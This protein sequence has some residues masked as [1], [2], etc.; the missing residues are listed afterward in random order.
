MAEISEQTEAIIERLK[1]EG[2]LVRNTG[3]N[4]IKAV[5]M[6][7]AKFSGIFSTISANIAEQTEIMRQTLEFDQLAAKKAA[8]EA[9]KQQLDEVARQAED[10]EKSK[11]KKDEERKKTKNET[12]SSGGVITSFLSGFKNLLVKSLLGGAGAV[13]LFEV[14][15]GFFDERTQGGFSKFFEEIDWTKMTTDMKYIAT[16]IASGAK[17]FVNFVAD[18]LGTILGSISG[19]TAGAA[20][21]TAAGLG[22]LLN[23]ANGDDGDTTKRRSKL[24]N[25]VKLSALGLVLAGVGVA[26]DSAKE[27]IDKQEFSD[28]EIAGVKVGEL[29]KFGVD[30][31]DA[32]LRGASIGMM[33]GPQGAMVGAVLGA[34]VTI[35][36]KAWEFWTN[37]K[38]KNEERM[39]KDIA[40]M[41]NLMN[42]SQAK[43]RVEYIQNELSKF[44]AGSLRQ[45]ERFNELK[46]TQFYQGLTEDQQGALSRFVFSG[47]TIPGTSRN[48]EE[49]LQEQEK[50][51]TGQRRRGF[52]IDENGMIIG[53]D[54]NGPLG[55]SIGG[56]EALRL[57]E[58]GQIKY[59]EY[60]DKKIA[61]GQLP[62]GAK[63][64]LMNS[65]AQA[66][67]QALPK[68]SEGQETARIKAAINAV[69]SAAGEGSITASQMFDPNDPRNN[70]YTGYNIG[71]ASTVFKGLSTRQQAEINRGAMFNAGVE[72]DDKGNIRLIM[73]DAFGNPVPLTNAQQKSA[74]GD[75]LTR[76][77]N[78]MRDDT[79][80]IV[81][82]KQ[83]DNIRYGDHITGGTSLAVQSQVGVASPLALGS[84]FPGHAN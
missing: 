41:E 46:E 14:A 31:A 70:M 26:A 23:N 47:R 73:Y 66:F 36:F 1:A 61:A 7:L 42:D 2:Q 6:D 44:R 79:G 77:T 78:L 83:G 53:T 50:Y 4:S 38:A 19:P 56:R 65:W 28:N 63:S 71:A 55:R 12:K 64:D 51:F 17:N 45:I 59:S 48:L 29:A 74:L 58:E 20:V 60:L 49:F 52:R 76:G 27:W 40:E 16:T 15:R 68:L 57:F 24:R 5:K 81:M 39:R 37:M 21:V 75:M 9:R 62:P 80:K 8:D 3:S 10:E 54:P 22:G 18:P 72:F 35:G 34:T 43:S 33:F 82:I 25:F 30:I 11:Q 13:A 32:A 67:G 69:Q 84:E